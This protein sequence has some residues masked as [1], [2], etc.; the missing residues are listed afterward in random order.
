MPRSGNRLAQHALQGDNREIIDLTLV[1]VEI[2]RGKIGERSRHRGCATA[3]KD[4]IGV[5]LAA[6]GVLAHFLK[7][8]WEHDT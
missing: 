8:I 5:A 3:R 1:L 7:D 6:L 2:G 4:T